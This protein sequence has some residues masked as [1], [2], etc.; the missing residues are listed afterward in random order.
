MPSFKILKSTI[1]NPKSAF[2][3]NYTLAIYSTANSV[4]IWQLNKTKKSLLVQK[5]TREL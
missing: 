3:V 5:Q 4:D 1:N 2:L